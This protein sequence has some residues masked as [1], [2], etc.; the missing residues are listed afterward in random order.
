MHP[1]EV[2]NTILPLFSDQALRKQITLT[3]AVSASVPPVLASVGLVEELFGNLIS[4]AIK[5]TPTGE[6]VKV[7]LNS[8]NGGMVT[9]EVA[10]T[11][12]GMSETDIACLCSRFFRAENAKRLVI[13][14]TG[15]SLVIVKEILERLGGT[16]QVSS[17]VGEGSCFICRIPGLPCNNQP[18]IS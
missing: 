15:L 5:Y 1:C 18:E 6:R 11:G 9:F 16:I 3:S 17:N 12:T 4:N 10:D 2:L 7:S 14:G 13:E 8:E